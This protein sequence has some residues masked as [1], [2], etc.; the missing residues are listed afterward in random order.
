M[1]NL[2]HPCIF[3]KK[4]EIGFAIIVVYIDN[5]NLAGTLEELTKTTKYLKK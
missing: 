1:N 2:I 5:L 4:L 3:I